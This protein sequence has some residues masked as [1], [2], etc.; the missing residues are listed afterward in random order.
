MNANIMSSD[1]SRA[2]TELLAFTGVFYTCR[3]HSQ[4]LTFCYL[5]S[6]ARKGGVDEPFAWDSREYLRKLCIGKV[7]IP[8]VLCNYLLITLASFGSYSC[9]TVVVAQ[10]V[11]FKV[12]YTVPSIGREFGSVFL[13]DKN[14][15]MLVVAEGWAKVI[16]SYFLHAAWRTYI[17]GSAFLCES[18]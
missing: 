4:V 11:T 17:F 13:G 18:W 9:V 1:Q 6:K 14:V 16:C 8:S 15:A 10:E 12:D 3:Q 7:L 5:F 2:H